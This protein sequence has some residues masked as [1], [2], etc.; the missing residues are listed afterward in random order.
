MQRVHRAGFVAVEMPDGTL[1]GEEIENRSASI[2][3]GVSIR[4]GPGAV[5]GGV[6]RVGNQERGAVGFGV[7]AAFGVGEE[8]EGGDGGEDEGGDGGWWV[9]E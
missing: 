4:G 6:E 9:G 1:R 2:A 7:V 3:G 8:G 5:E